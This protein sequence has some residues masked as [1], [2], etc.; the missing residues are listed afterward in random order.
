MAG[1]VRDK[2]GI[3]RAFNGGVLHPTTTRPRSHVATPTSALC[4]AQ[5]WDGWKAPAQWY[6]SPPTLGLPFRWCGKC[7][8][9][10]LIHFGGIDKAVEQVVPHFTQE[11]AH[12]EGN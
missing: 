7:V 2:P 1:P 3:Y 11:V 8:G 10:A 12:A 6:D 4:G 5:A 9:I